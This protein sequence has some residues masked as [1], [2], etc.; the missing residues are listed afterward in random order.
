MR[1]ALALD[2]DLAPFHRR[3]RGDPLLGPTIRRRPWLRPHRVAEPFEALMWAITEQLIE[4]ERAWRIQRRIVWRYGR[5]TACGSL[6]SAPS[7]SR[8]AARAPAELEACDL[9]ARRAQAMITAARE[10]A[11]GRVDLA[12]HEPSW[13][14][15][16]RISHIGSWTLE[17]LA[18]HGQ[19]R[20]DQLAAGDLGYLTLVGRLAELGRRATEDEVRAF[21]AP[22]APYAALAGL[23]ALRAPAGAG[24][25]GHRPRRPRPAAARW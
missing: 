19:G 22:Y 10:V 3:F 5:S 20:D 9:A 7:P 17:K 11:A 8:V 1:F 24:T 6:R 15:L 25:L 16:R 14:R 12:E 18:V 2:H 23:Y 4:T 13:S 21:F